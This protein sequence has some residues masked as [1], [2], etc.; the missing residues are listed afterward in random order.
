[1]NNVIYVFVFF[2]FISCNSSKKS[3]SGKIETYEE[4]AISKLGERISYVLNETESYV[5]CINEVEGT[6]LKPRN[7]ITY[8]VVD[9][10]TSDIVYE[11]KLSGGSVKWFDDIH[12]EERIISGILKDSDLPNE[13]GKVINI[14][15]SEVKA[16]SSLRQQNER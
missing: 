2:I 5:L 8:L 3:S 12:I 16:K 6:N 9:V 7:L 14:I 15:T 4:V 10:K 11:S 13:T 1:M